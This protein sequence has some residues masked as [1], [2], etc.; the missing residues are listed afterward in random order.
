MDYT[1]NDEAR[2]TR[3]A[4]QQLR[5]TQA[6][7]PLAERVRLIKF[8]RLCAETNRCYAPHNGAWWWPFLTQPG[9]RRLLMPKLRARVDAQHRATREKYAAELRESSRRFAQVKAERAAAKVRAKL[10][11]MELLTGMM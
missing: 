8:W 10:P 7:D 2:A 6:D 5:K 9:F 4:R 3:R 1:A 11:Q